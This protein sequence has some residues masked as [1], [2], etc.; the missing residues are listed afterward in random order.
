MGLD[1]I[2]DGFIRVGLVRKALFLATGGVSGLVLKAPPKRRP[3]SKP[4]TT[5]TGRAK[6]AKAS[7]TQARKAARPKAAKPIQKVRRPATAKPAR[8]KARPARRTTAKAPAR[9]RV[10]AKASR[11][12]QSASRPQPA[13]A[14][15][16]IP[17]PEPG[18]ITGTEPF[19]RPQTGITPPPARPEVP[20][21]DPAS[22]D[23]VEASAVAARRLAQLA[24]DEDRVAAPASTNSGAESRN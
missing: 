15:A 6:P 7:R 21:R 24:S 20:V 3:A 18:V 17:S 4:A 2:R 9:P 16:P 5:S 19:A 22:Y 1:F 13:S 11:P 12:A 23:A 8:A 14:P 10:T